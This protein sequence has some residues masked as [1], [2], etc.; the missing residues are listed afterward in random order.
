MFFFYLKFFLLVYYYFFFSILLKFN[1]SL[2]KGEGVDNLTWV[3]YK[4]IP[5]ISQFGME[6]NDCNEKC[7]CITCPCHSLALTRIKL[8]GR[9]SSEDKTKLSWS[10]RTFLGWKKKH[11]LTRIFLEGKVNT[12]T[13]SIIFFQYHTRHLSQLYAKDGDH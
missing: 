10:S 12:S 8:S 1:Y 11:N 13:C 9:E 2:I 7:L 5:I 3:R 4:I 6:C